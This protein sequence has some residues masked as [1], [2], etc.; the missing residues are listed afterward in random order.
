MTSVINLIVL[1]LNGEEIFFC[2]SLQQDPNI[3][4]NGMKYRMLLLSE[5]MRCQGYLSA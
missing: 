3:V 1:L 4:G 2:C 5:I